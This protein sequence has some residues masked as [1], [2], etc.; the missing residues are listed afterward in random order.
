M[1]LPMILLWK[2]ASAPVSPPFERWGVPT[3]VMLPLSGVPVHFVAF[4]MGEVE[5]NWSFLYTTKTVNFL[6]D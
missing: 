4:M 3:L 2:G 6:N 5:N 1:K